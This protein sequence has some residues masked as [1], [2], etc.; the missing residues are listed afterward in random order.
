MK[1]IAAMLAALVIAAP[2]WAQPAP[3]P[4]RIRGTITKVEGDLVELKTRDGK[5]VTLTMAP[6]M[7]VLGLKKTDLS[8]VQ[9]GS[10]IGCTSAPGP[11]GV[12]RALEVHVFPPAMKGTG[13]GDRAWDLGANSS[14]TN[15]TVG[16][17][18]MSNGR[19]MTITYSGGERQVFVP[20]DTPIVQGEPGDRSL[21]TPGTHVIAFPT[22]AADGSLVATRMNVGLNGTVPPM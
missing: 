21:L 20:D 10:Y 19:V 3:T 6:A 16:D 17:L 4:A 14:M 12:A 11:D 18:K 22:K 8:S 9:P 5:D 1:R 7:G 13:E 15:G 2:A